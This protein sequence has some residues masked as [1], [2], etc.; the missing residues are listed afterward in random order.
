MAFGWK[1]ASPAC[2]KGCKNEM[3][4][5]LKDDI[6]L[7]K[8]GQLIVLEHQQGCSLK[9]KIKTMYPKKKGKFVLLLFYYTKWKLREMYMLR[10]FFFEG[11]F[12]Y[13]WVKQTM[14]FLAVQ[15]RPYRVPGIKFKLGSCQANNLPLYYL[16]SHQQVRYCMHWYGT[17]W[18]TQIWSSALHN[19]SKPTVSPS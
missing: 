11:G 3:R 6:S 1:K 18:T 5:K 12:C 7:L 4:N 17:H 19:L 8:P 9:L 16:S 15:R 13:F 2:T 10:H 14:L